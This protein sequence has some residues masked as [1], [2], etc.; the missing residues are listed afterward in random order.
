MRGG[1]QKGLTEEYQVDGEFQL[2]FL[3]ILPTVL[4][5]D[6]GLDVDL[7]THVD[8]DFELVGGVDREGLVVFITN[9]DKLD[10]FAE[11]YTLDFFCGAFIPEVEF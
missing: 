6:V 7:G 11:N 3:I 9:C 8:L 5:V 4:E 2:Y 1:D 10:V